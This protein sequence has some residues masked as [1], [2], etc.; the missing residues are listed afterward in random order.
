MLSSI[1][2]FAF[3]KHS[4]P[5]SGFFLAVFRHFLF[6]YPSLAM[7]KNCPHSVKMRQLRIEKPNHNGLTEKLQVPAKKRGTDSSEG[8]GVA[9]GMEGEYNTEAKTSTGPSEKAVPKAQPLAWKYRTT[10]EPKPLSGTPFFW[11][12]GPALF[13]V[14]LTRVYIGLGIALC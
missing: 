6:S 3:L 9:F 1:S 13:D 14:F 2:E 4:K 7:P 11:L 8:Y 5:R 10:W 12:T